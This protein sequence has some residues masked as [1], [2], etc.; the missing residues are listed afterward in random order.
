MFSHV[1]EIFN[2]K[3][4]LYPIPLP[5]QPYQ[6]IYRLKVKSS[7]HLV[8]LV[9]YHRLNFGDRARLITLHNPGNINTIQ[10]TLSSSVRPATSQLISATSC[11][12]GLFCFLIFDFPLFSCRG[13]E[14]A[15][16]PARTVPIVRITP[17]NDT[18]WTAC[19]RLRIHTHHH[20][21][22]VKV[23]REDGIPQF[24]G[25][26]PPLSHP[27]FSSWPDSRDI[28]V[29]P[30][31]AEA[32]MD[33]VRC[34]ATLLCRGGRRPLLASRSHTLGPGTVSR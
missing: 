31:Q 7:S 3:L 33:G 5:K 21:Y 8:F 20:S 16:S 12:E 24:T 17:R 13:W 27:V 26:V 4:S 9:K 34:M 23:L 15:N 25:H 32:W 18:T 11:Y 1:V 10:L 28:L 14:S 30:F 6:L 19:S 22:S 2:F 29:L